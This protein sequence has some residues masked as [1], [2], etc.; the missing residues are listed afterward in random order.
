MAFPQTPLDARL[1]LLIDGTWATVP[2]YER[3]TIEVETGRRE[4]AAVTDPGSLGVTIN[5]RLGRYSP[6]NPLSDLYGK[7]GRNTPCR[8]S[9][10][11]SES[12]LELKDDAGFASTPD[13]AELD[14][15][16]NL[17]LRWE[18]EAD[19]YAAGSQFL[20]G[21]WD[22]A[23]QR[24]YHLR[25][26][27][28]SVVLH[29]TTNGTSGGFGGGLLPALPRR[30]A[31]R[32]TVTIGADWT[33]RLYWAP[34]LDGPWTPAGAPV[35]VAGAAPIFAGSSALRIAPAE[36]LDTTP[37]RRRFTGRCYRA[38]VR[39]GID[40]T[41]VA[42][43]DFRGLA[44]GT[45]AFT[46]SA[47]RAWTV[48][49]TA[50][51]RDRAD[52]FF[53]EVSEW[54]QEWTL[55][56]A[57]A[58]VRI[59]GA[60]ILRRL[61][62]G[63]KPLQSTLR[64]RLPSARPLVYWPME[65]GASAVQAASALDGG[66]PLRVTGFQFASEDSLPSSEALPVLGQAATLYGAVPGATAGGWH[67]E[68]V[69]KLEKLPATE[70]T[71]LRLRLAPGSGGVVEI[72]V[73]V[74]TTAI[75]MEAL[76]AD[77]G[78]VAWFQN[79]TGGVPAFVGAWNRL[80]V[81]S[82]VSGGQARATVAWRDVITGVWWYIHAPWTGTPGR[83]VAVQGAWGTGFQGMAVGHLAVW[84]TGSSSPTAPAVTV[85]EGSDDGYNGETAWARMRRLAGEENLPLARI[86][87]PE[88]PQRVGPQT[89]DTLLT[90]LQAAADTDGGLLLE[91][92]RRA[93][94]LYRDRSSLYSQ[95]P[96]LTLS[97]N[98]RPGLKAPLAPVDDDTAVRNDRTVKRA[99]GSEARAVLEDGP[100]SVQN[101]PEGIGVYDDSVTLPLYSDAQAAP[102]AHWRL[103]LGTVDTVRYPTVRIMLHK[104][105]ELIPNILAL[106]E[107]DLVRITDLPRW[108][109]YGQ[110]DLIVEG[111]RHEAGLQV[112]E[113][114]LSC[115]PG[116]PWQVAAVG[117]PVRGRV[118]TSGST[119]TTAVDADTTTLT[120]D[121]PAWVTAGIPLNQN[122]D[123]AADLTG[124]SGFGAT[125]ERVE[126]PAPAPTAG[127][128]ALQLVPD[129]VAEFPNAGSEQIPVT[130][131]AQ[132]MVSGWLRCA[133][134]RPVA[135]NVNWFGPG[136]A[137]L[138]TSATDHPVTA[139]EWTW[140]QATVTAPA[141]AVTANLAPTVADFPPETDV[142]WVQQATLRPAGGMP[143]HFPIDVQ[144]G[145]EV[146]TVTGISGTS[147]QTF[148]VTRAVN[149]ISKPHAAGTTVRV[150][151]PFVFAL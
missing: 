80:Q 46:D 139:D 11:S 41:V 69:Y 76:N 101:P 35:V 133:R 86:A 60:G 87:G 106:S 19:W 26:Q 71:F 1:E 105:P 112:W 136:S 14:I 89:V 15:T 53:G 10:P 13:A 12:Y 115:S 63:H 120:V 66:L 137:Y 9:V 131:G 147:P 27:D 104:A 16:G 52:L 102:I 30:A 132:Y 129:G 73:R 23:G 34:S 75:K 59:A 42:R 39:N 103:H 72:R 25:L 79:D 3:D 40:G 130:V 90:L 88:T 32:G 126:A 21:K 117:D 123:F 127:K 4:L 145:G 33:F 28:G 67:A 31:L 134:T 124:W 83:V 111:I 81:F 114:E 92:R 6:R 74:S 18:G 57:D 55:D 37:P 2:T 140:I 97:Y 51:V 22:A 121:G 77:G 44:G 96:K 95:T 107:G 149:G 143:V 45:A 20:V 62:Q 36:Q 78:V 151:Q 116:D 98:Q 54:P 93:G 48:S 122:P 5:N 148:T 68:L 56:E 49:G 119:L 146:M 94:L 150:H 61:G 70:Q 144:V 99:G 100:L 113:V 50:T 141:G 135:L 91:D 110:T 38:E 84:D 17:D 64:R 142:L 82:S 128:W 24:S 7:I 65:D 43:P 108:V 8:L 138:S 125:I 47:G 29:V 109:G 118:D 58:W 85:Y